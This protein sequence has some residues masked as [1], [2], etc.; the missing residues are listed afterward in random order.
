[1]FQILCFGVSSVEPSVFTRG[2]LV[3]VLYLF[4]N[5]CNN[6]FSNSVWLLVSLLNI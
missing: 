1:M 4:Y 6:V 5:V 2:V 3:S